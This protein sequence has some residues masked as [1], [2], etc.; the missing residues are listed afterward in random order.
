[1]RGGSRPAKNLLLTAKAL[2]G[3]TRARKAYDGIVANITSDL[4]GRDQL[5]TIDNTFVAAFAGVAVHVGDLN[6][7]LL[8]GDHIDLGE[9]AVV[10]SSLVRIA[11]RLGVHRR[12]REVTPSLD[13]Y[14]RSKRHDADEVKVEAAE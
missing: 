9:H 8:R 7:K 12:P 5:N 3:R 1:M 14:L 13:H 11:S 6:A 4:G 2:D 10:V